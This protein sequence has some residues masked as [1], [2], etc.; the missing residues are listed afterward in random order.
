VA[1]HIRKDL[2]KMQVPWD[3]LPELPPLEKP[4]DPVRI[5]EIPGDLGH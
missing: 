5:G 3:A 4:T 2:R 1:G